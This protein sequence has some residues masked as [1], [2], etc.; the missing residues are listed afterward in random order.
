MDECDVDF[1]NGEGRV[2]GE[3][4]Q[5]API[6]L[7]QFTGSSRVGELLS[8]QTRGKVKVED[9]GFDWKILGPDVEDFDFVAW[10][11]D[12]DAYAC[13]GQKCSA[14][15]ICF[16][17]ENWVKAGFVDRIADIASKRK[18]E[19]LSIGPVLSHTTGEMLAHKDR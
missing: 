16:M 18:L 1:L 9:A 11:S 10:Q 15:S 3:L 7:T 8:E 2:M 5:R 13:S 6:R 17:H 12:Q 4:I 14:Q 19:D